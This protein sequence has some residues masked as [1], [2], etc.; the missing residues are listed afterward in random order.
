M[1][2]VNFILL[3]FTANVDT[4]H[5]RRNFDYQYYEMVVS[6]ICANLYRSDFDLHFTFRQTQH[7]M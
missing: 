5:S 2:H 6:R 7:S 1:T 3:S 4:K